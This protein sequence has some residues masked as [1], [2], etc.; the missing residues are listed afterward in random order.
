M[1]ARF[2]RFFLSE[3]KLRPPQGPKRDI[4]LNPPALHGTLT[5]RA[6]FLSDCFLGL[7]PALSPKGLSPW[8]RV[9][10]HA[11]AYGFIFIAKSTIE[12]MAM[13]VGP[14]AS[15]GRPSSI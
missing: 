12:R 6:I 11:A 10:L 3:L 15:Q 14:L 5:T 13:P 1:G 8:R 9:D 4:G 2:A 7:S